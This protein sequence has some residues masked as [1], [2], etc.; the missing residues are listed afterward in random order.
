M[1][2]S[3]PAHAGMSS[4]GWVLVRSA[5]GGEVV[6]V[7]RLASILEH[8]AIQPAACSA[9]MSQRVPRREKAALLIDGEG[10][11]LTQ[12]EQLR[13]PESRVMSRGYR[14]CQGQF[15]AGASRYRLRRTTYRVY[16]RFG[17]YFLNCRH[18][19][20]VDAHEAAADEG[21]YCGGKECILFWEDG[22]G[23]LSRL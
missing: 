12:A 9:S 20:S 5:I 13:N 1:K 3:L 18:W 17:R 23:A 2:S 4:P 21:E 14:R 15:V 22:G 16:P 8:A 11:L 7:A 19:G 10:V 6:N